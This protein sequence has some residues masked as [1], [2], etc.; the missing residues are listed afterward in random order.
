[1]S[2]YCHAQAS[3][4]VGESV[5]LQGPELMRALLIAGVSLTALVGRAWA[6]DV[7]LVKAPISPALPG[8]W[9]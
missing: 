7:P 1:V 5:V 4:K 6:D 2:R 9:K 3:K 8:Y